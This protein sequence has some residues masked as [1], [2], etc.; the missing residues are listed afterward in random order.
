MNIVY[1]IGNGFDINLDMKTSYANFYEYYI[2]LPRDNDTD[3]VKSFKEELCKNKNTEYWSDLEIAL[4]NYLSKL[5][6]NG[7]VILHEHLIDHLSSYIAL[8]DN[9][10]FNEKDKDTFHEY[11]QNPHVNRL[12]PVEI[13]E[14]NSLRLKWERNNWDIK[15]ITFNYTKSIEK[16]TDYKD[17]TIQIRTRRVTNSHRPSNS[18]PPYQ[19]LSINLSAIEHIHGFTDERMILG[20]NDI[21]Q[22][23]NDNLRK[24]TAIIDRYVKTEC[25]TT[26][27]V[28][29][30]EKCQKWINEA[31]LICLFGLS[32]G[33]TD[34]K[35]WEIVGKALERDCRVIIFEYNSKEKFNKNQGPALKA[36][37]EEVKNKFL[38]KTN[39]EE[40]MK[41][42]TKKKIYIAYNTDMFKFIDIKKK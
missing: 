13:E 40:N 8:Q 24:E 38:S 42:E 20:V 16:L 15:I 26:Y 25:N 6:A 21:S 31:H 7:A 34:R 39:I 14:I 18:V 11:L 10:S 37:K 29:H 30:D 3:V 27:G 32:F 12:L 41:S 35:W 5:E 33:D 19:Q 9:L 17:E 23:A 22:I 2:N 28:N 1:L 4:G 36:K